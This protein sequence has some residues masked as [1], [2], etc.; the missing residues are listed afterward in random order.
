L[1]RK[2][3]GIEADSLESGHAIRARPPVMQ[4]TPSKTSTDRLGGPLTPKHAFGREWTVIRTV[5][6][7]QESGIGNQD[8]GN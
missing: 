4:I 1:R 6:V 2:N 3:F 8:S 7:N 5:M